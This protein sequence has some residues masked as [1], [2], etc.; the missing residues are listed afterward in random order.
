MGVITLS[1]STIVEKFGLRSAVPSQHRLIKLEI[2]VGTMAGISG[3][4]PETTLLSI[5]LKNL[6]SPKY[7][8]CVAIS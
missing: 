6:S 3:R 5:S 8:F 7:R 4:S 2:S 1:V